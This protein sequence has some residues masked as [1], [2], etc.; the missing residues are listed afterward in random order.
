ML[1]SKQRA[2]R[3]IVIEFKTNKG[4]ETNLTHTAYNALKQIYKLDYITNLKKSGVD[5]ENIY[6][7]EFAFDGKNVEILG[8]DYAEMDWDGILKEE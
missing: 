5:L 2:N 4:N 1:I 7:Y 3:G 8:G 6:V